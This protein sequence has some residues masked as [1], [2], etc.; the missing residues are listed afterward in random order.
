MQT[1]GSSETRIWAVVPVKRLA[2]AKQRLSIALGTHRED[3]A[4]E[5]AARTVATVRDSGVFHGI[6]VVTSDAIVSSDAEAAGAVVVVDSGD[7]LNDAVSLGIAAIRERGGDVCAVVPADLATAT[8]SG[9]K[10]LVAEYLGL[11]TTVG[12]GAIGF[13]R[14]KEG[15]GT[16]MVFLDPR[17]A[18][19]PA[20]GVNS[21]AKHL[22]ST[23]G[24]GRELWGGEAAF[25]IDTTED[26][27]LLATK[28]SSADPLSKILLRA[29]T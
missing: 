17:C 12:E 7:S 11:R 14:C 4:R 2:M 6:L 3:F 20:F 16:N 9:I 27:N 19:H 26:L 18:F 24:H 1:H 29:C 15:T 5:L 22:A 21:F 8:P 28:L 10:R 23:S 13:V 25:D